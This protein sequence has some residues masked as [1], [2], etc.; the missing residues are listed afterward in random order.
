MRLADAA[1]L[2]LTQ[3]SVNATS[4]RPAKRRRSQGRVVRK[5][6]LSRHGGL[7]VNGFL[8]LPSDASSPAYA[9]SRR[10]AQ[11][12]CFNF[13]IVVKQGTNWERPQE[14]NQAGPGPL[15]CPGPSRFEQL[16]LCS[17]LRVLHL[18]KASEY[19]AILAATIGNVF[20]TIR[21]AERRTV[22]QRLLPNPVSEW[23]KNASCRS[24]QFSLLA[25]QEARCKAPAEGP[26]VGSK[27]N[28]DSV[29]EF[30]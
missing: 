12:F 11:R 10:G 20:R 16:D 14:W 6:T 29:C 28:G 18:E 27:L 3:K 15:R 5:D 7:I 26:R 19:R 9:P 8:S 13:W 24:G 23:C 22:P 21:H 2:N 4:R 1:R 25:W 17:P 30:C